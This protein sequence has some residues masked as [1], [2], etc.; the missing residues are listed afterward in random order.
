M[1]DSTHRITIQQIG[2]NSGRNFLVGIAVIGLLFYLMANGTLFRIGNY[3][4]GSE[5]SG[6]QGY[7][8]G[9]YSSVTGMA[10]GILIP[11]ISTIGALAVAIVTGAWA[12]LW[13]VITGIRD[14]IKAYTA[15]NQAIAAATN[16]ATN[17]AVIEATRTAMSADPSAATQGIGLP[18]VIGAV[19]KIAEA[20]DKLT[21]DVA[22][23]KAVPAPKAAAKP[24][25]RKP[26]SPVVVPATVASPVTQ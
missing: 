14:T 8:A 11:V 4:S 7:S 13:D 10:L 17:Q 6:E 19:E 25:A 23:L 21:E 5:F 24:R 9:G 20:V 2:D 1:T 22:A 12:V 3:F 18:Q 26:A 16:V 15:K